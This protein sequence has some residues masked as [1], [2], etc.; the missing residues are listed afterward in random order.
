MPGRSYAQ[1]RPCGGVPVA[2]WLELVLNLRVELEVSAE[3]ARKEKR[4]GG[5]TM[6]VWRLASHH[7]FR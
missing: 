5:V 3:W 4:R 1:P 2:M 7:W 6:W